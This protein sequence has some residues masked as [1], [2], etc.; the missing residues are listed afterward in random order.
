MKKTILLLLFI[1]FVSL[2]NAQR[3]SATQ[4]A[5]PYLQYPSSPLNANIETYFSKIINKSTAVYAANS[6][7]ML[8]GYQEVDYL[9]SADL[10]I[11]FIINV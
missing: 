7:L 2:L 11:K 9:D 5:I 4:I 6:K 3:P 1:P 8:E 10:E